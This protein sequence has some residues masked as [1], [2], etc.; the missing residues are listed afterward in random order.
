MN[1]IRFLTVRQTA[2]TGLISE[3]R[4]RLLVA[5]G[6]VPGVYSGNRFMVNYDQ[7]VDLLNA[8]SL[9]NAGGTD[10]ADR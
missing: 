4:L 7:L 6:R 5:Q 1:T 8:Q 2:R 10:N 3:Y 9:E